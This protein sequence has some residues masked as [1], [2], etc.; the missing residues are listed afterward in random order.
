MK[1]TFKQYLTET[2]AKADGRWSDFKIDK[3]VYSGKMVRI[4]SGTRMDRQ[5]FETQ[6]RNRGKW[7][8]I[9]YANNFEEAKTVPT[10]S[11]YDRKYLNNWLTDDEKF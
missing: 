6:V 11:E 4:Y 5:L 10:M 1:K 9:Q 3:L 7:V 2:Y 8:T